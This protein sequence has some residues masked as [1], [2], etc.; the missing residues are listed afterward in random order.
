MK[1][2]APG[3]ETMSLKEYYQV[4]EG[5]AIVFMDDKLYERPAKLHDGKPYLDLETV[6]KRFLKRLFLDERD[7]LLTFTTATKIMRF[8]PNQMGVTVNE[9]ELSYPEL[10][11]FTEGEE[12]YVSLRFVAEYADMSYQTYTADGTAEEPIQR[13][14][15]QCSYGDYLYVNTNRA[16][17]IRTQDDRKSAIL[18]ELEA[19][20]PRM[21][22][23]GGG[24]QENGFYKVMTPDGVLGYVNKKHVSEGY[25]KKL[26]SSFQ[27]EQYENISMEQP[28]NLTWHYVENQKGNEGLAELIAQTKGVNVVSPTWFRLEGNEGDFLSL[29][30]ESYVAK[31]HE[32]G[33]AVWGLVKNFD[34]GTQTDTYE[35]LSKASSRMKLA[36]GL[37]QE[38]CTFGIEGINVDFELISL[39]TGPYFVQF[40]R[41]LSVLCRNAGLVL[42]VD[43]Y[44]P[45]NYNK[46]YD[47]AE[48]GVVADYVIIM[49]YDEHTSVSGEAGS[50]ASISYVEK[51]IKDTVAMVPADKIIIGVPFYT[52]LWKEVET[53]DGTVVSIAQ[54]PFMRAAEKLLN[55]RGITP[56]WDEETGQYYAEC[57][58]D[59]AG[60][61]IWLEEERSIAE[62][63]I[64]VRQAG[65]AGIASWRLGLEKKEI[66]DV[67]SEYLNVLQ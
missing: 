57:E 9:E 5:E 65:V 45:E 63:L 8:V 49:A 27:A 28:V 51:A 35:V 15:I 33:L 13:I 24:A 37:V 22:I 25:F 54:T 7:G 34:T 44:V 31:A 55:E 41:E 32:L 19:E 60:Y 20:R 23:D 12:I 4:P 36:K 64:R 3:T 10:I 48:Q 17:Q 1:Y 67:I 50:V 58:E 26:E 2:F 18:C 56:E 16:T 47:Y 14:M 43:N 53:P 61:R 59:G 6:Q 62:K 66:W 29:A 46:Y 38:A 30:S 11:V 39:E 52:R 21:L 40:I 42:S